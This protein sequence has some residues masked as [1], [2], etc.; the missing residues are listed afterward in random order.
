MFP[1]KIPNVEPTHVVLQKQGVFRETVIVDSVIMSQITTTQI[2]VKTAERQEGIVRIGLRHLTILVIEA[3][4]L[5]RIQA[6][7]GQRLVAQQGQLQ[8]ALQ[9]VHLAL[10]GE[11]K[12]VLDS[13][14]F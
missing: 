8:A 10:Q 12:L 9:E 7:E 4:P 5:P 2:Q 6:S 1:T 11:D 14:E 3:P 13:I